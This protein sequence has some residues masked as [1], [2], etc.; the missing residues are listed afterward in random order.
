LRI[1]AGAGRFVVGGQSAIRIP[2]STIRNGSPGS[3]G[4]AGK[5]N[6][7]CEIFNILIALRPPEGRA[8]YPA[9]QDDLPATARTASAASQAA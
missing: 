4:A 2:R 1:V 8:F 3:A 5:E 7:E 6:I 9:R